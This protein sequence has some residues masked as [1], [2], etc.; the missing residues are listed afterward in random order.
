MT[1]QKSDIENSRG[2]SRRE[3][4]KLAAMTSLLAG[5]SAG[6]P[7]VV[8]P[9]SEPPTPPRP[10]D[11]PVST[12]TPR[13][14]PLPTNTSLPTNTPLPTNTSVPTATPLPTNTSAPTATLPPPTPTISVVDSTTEITRF[15]PNVPSKVVYARHTG[16]WDGDALSVEVI[17]QMLDASITNLTGL[18]DAT[19]A[20]AALFR[21][22]ER[23]AIKVNTIRNSSYWT[24]LS[25]VDAVTEKLQVIGIAPEQIVI[26]DRFTSELEN[27]GFQINQNGAGVRCYGQD[28][29]Y[30]SGYTIMEQN[31][32]L[33]SI[34]LECDA[35]INIPL[36]KQHS[37]TGV[38]FGMKNHYGTF[39]QP[40]RFHGQRAA[41]AIPQLNGLEPIKDRTRLIIGDVFDVVQSGWYHSAPGDAILMSFDPV[42]HDAVGL[43][44]YIDTMTAAGNDRA[45]AAA[46]R[47]ADGWLLNGT[48]MGLGTNN[49]D[50]IDV[51][52][53]NLA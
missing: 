39:D 2:L 4:I 29:N 13:E 35:L 15:Y 25:L 34:L 41:T 24:H 28:G 16:V 51:V 32:G 8:V 21:T 46:T 48:E 5:C 31:I 7:A 23:I 1:R 18:N 38:S 14:T 22:D 33:S 11:S 52:E 30:T 10:T 45:V 26:F 42:A 47:L 17:N 37:I 44:I 19:E 3:F 50:N 49:F 27:A 53:V 6:P 36:L 20:W 40:G 43:Q 12:A 9:T